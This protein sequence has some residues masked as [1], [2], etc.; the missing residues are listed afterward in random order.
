[1]KGP[2]RREQ[3]PQL[4]P[5]QFALGGLAAVLFFAL[6]FTVVALAGGEGEGGGGPVPDS[7]PGIE[8]DVDVDRPHPRHSAQRSGSAQPGVGK[9]T[10]TPRAPRTTKASR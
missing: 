3:R 10:A 4:T 9:S 8:V 2:Q 6:L 5:A 7:G 1:M